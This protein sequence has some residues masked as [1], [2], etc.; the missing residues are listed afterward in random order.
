MRAAPLA[1]LIALT[2]SAPAAAEVT[3]PDY[4]AGLERICRPGAERTEAA[5]RGV[6]S[7]LRDQR[8]ALAAAKFSA[9]GRI[10]AHTLAAIEPRPRPTPDLARLRRWFSLLARQRSYLAQ[11]AAALRARRIPRSQRLTAHFVHTGNLANRTVLGF[12]FDYCSF[13][14]SRYT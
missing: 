4:V 11:I 12:G 13:R 10:F 8:L 14:F 5:V 3:R 7:D 9:A 2:L 1:L 6:R